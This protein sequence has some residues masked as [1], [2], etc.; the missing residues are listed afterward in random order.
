MTPAQVA[1]RK[2]QIIDEALREIGAGFDSP[3]PAAAPEPQLVVT[4]APVAPAVAPAAPPTVQVRRPMFASEGGPAPRPSF[5]PPATPEQAAAHPIATPE[6]RPVY[7]AQ[8]PSF[9]P[10]LQ[11]P[12]AAPPMRSP[13]SRMAQLAGGGAGPSVGRKGPDFGVIADL[14][15]GLFPGIFKRRL[16]DKEAEL[17]RSSRLAE[18]AAQSESQRAQREQAM[19]DSAAEYERGAPERAREAQRFEWDSADRQREQAMR[20]PGSA[21]STKAREAWAKAHPEFF[22]ARFGSSPETFAKIAAGDTNT[23]DMLNNSATAWEA[24]NARAALKKK[25]GA[26]SGVPGAGAQAGAEESR[27]IGLLADGDVPGALAIADSIGGKAGQRIRERAARAIEAERAQ[28]AKESERTASEGRKDTALLDKQ[29]NEYRKATEGLRKSDVPL[30]FM[31]SYISSFG[32][33]DDIPT[34]G[35]ADRFKPG[36]WPGLSERDQQFIAHQN[37]LDEQFGRG[38]SGAAIGVKERADFQ[39][40]T[41]RRAATQAQF[42]AA[43]RSFR[44]YINTLKRVEA[45]GR[46]EA[47]AEVEAA[48][49]SAIGGERTYTVTDPRTGETERADLTDAQAESLRSKGLQVQ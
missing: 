23:W 14:F 24:Q 39:V 48:Q 13:S 17:S 27:A 45:A 28:K 21:E 22:A 29:R 44:E 33:N 10:A 5:A 4:P 41:G 16:M 32:P 8:R 9:V 31:E 47:A 1:L 12:T 6:P 11:P 15:P 25:G 38:Q 34:V 40:L 49:R 7:P 19:A 42:S 30:A 2:R 46:E 20:D 3:V 36:F 37:M 26:G 18:L 43:V 35:A